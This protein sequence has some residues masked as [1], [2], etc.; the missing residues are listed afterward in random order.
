M[1]A[2]ARVGPDLMV[3]NYERMCAAI[4]ACVQVDE[5]KDFHDRAKALE[6]YHH[7]AHNLQAELK[8]R[9]IRFRAGHRFGEL[10]RETAVSGER[11]TRGSAGGRGDRKLPEGTFKLAD[12]GTNKKQSSEWQELS[13]TPWAKVEAMLSKHA[14]KVMSVGS[15]LRQME[16]ERTPWMNIPR[17]N[18]TC[19]TC[20]HAW[21]GPEE[22]CPNCGKTT[23]EQFDRYTRM[24]QLFYNGP[25]KREFDRL[26][27]TLGQR[28]GTKN[29]SQ[30]V[31]EA[32]RREVAGA[33]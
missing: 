2:L 12:C 8:C 5:V 15:L 17:V 13:L 6:A 24:V 29:Q 18:H 28:Y 33:A 11:A 20:H 22:A 23:T 14:E 7:Q 30:T 1:S 19:W 3:G 21:D 10:L 25:G 31:I 9:L 32:L 27:Q 16:R 4:E 26:V